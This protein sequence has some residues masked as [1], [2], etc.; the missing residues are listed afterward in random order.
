MAEKKTTKKTTKKKTTTK[1]EKEVKEI[2]DNEVK[3]ENIK[4]KEEPKV[5]EKVKK[6]VRRPKKKVRID[7]DELFNVISNV[8]GELVFKAKD[9]SFEQTWSD[10]DDYAALTY[11]E[12]QK[13]RREGL[14]FFKDNWLV[15]EEQED[16]YSAEDVYAA[17]NVDKYYRNECNTIEDLEYLF[18]N[19]DTEEIKE[20]VEL[21]GTALKQ[22]SIDVV[23]GLVANG[24]I[25][26]R[27]RIN[28]LSSLLGYDFGEDA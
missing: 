8:T 1:K 9:N 20:E 22:K 15:I 21:M 28:L 25:D 7:R 10:S 13:I 14:R 26:S 27:S 3:T 5:E 2:V 23:Y 19:G 11:E 18:L 17:L 4:V 12:L 6:P 16:G 24:D